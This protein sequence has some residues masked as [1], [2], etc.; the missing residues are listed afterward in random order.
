MTSGHRAGCR[1]QLRMFS[2]QNLYHISSP[3]STCVKNLCLLSWTN[4]YEWPCFL[5]GDGLG[6]PF[7][8][9]L[10]LGYSVPWTQ[11][12][13]ASSQMM[14]PIQPPSLHAPPLQPGSRSV[15]PHVS[16]L[17]CHHFS[18][19]T[20]GLARLGD[21]LASYSALPP[22]SLRWSHFLARNSVSLSSHTHRP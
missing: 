12:L 15:G 7:P 3:L 1:L 22:P 17:F 8:L 4:Q 11:T 10:S 2:Y 18:S 5:G 6:R 19:R 13:Q 21:Y 9:S 16:S 20:Q 14:S